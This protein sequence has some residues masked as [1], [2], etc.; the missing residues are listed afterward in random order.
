MYKVNAQSDGSGLV[1]SV[2]VYIYTS[3]EVMLESLKE[4]L[5][6]H[7]SVGE[8]I[9]LMTLPALISDFM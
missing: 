4:D 6:L 1:D 9:T 3:L 5:E 8:K 2:F 7:S